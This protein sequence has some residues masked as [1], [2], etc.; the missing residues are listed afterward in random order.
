MPSRSIGAVQT[1][2]SPWELAALQTRARRHWWTFVDNE[3]DSLPL[4]LPVAFAAGIAAWF[5]LPWQGQRIAVAVGLAGTSAAPRLS[6]VGD[7]SRRRRCSPL[8]GWGLP[9]GDR[10][11]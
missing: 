1:A 4:W 6:V 5:L 3:R 8:P 2:P 11:V 10:R 7:H 9:N